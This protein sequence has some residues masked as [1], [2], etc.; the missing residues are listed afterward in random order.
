MAAIKTALVTGSTDGIGLHT[1]TRLANAGWRVLL[2]GRSSESVSAA[3]AAVRRAVPC[4]VLGEYVADLRTL[5]GAHSLATSVLASER[6][7]TCLINNAG[8]FQEA[9]ESAEGLDTTFA[10][11]VA[12]PFIL[13]VR[14]LPLLSLSRP[15]R[16]VN[17]SSISQNDFGRL[18]IGQLPSWSYRPWDPYA[19][20]SH[21]KVAVA[22]LSLELSYRAPVDATGVLVLS[23]DPGTVNTKM[24]IA[25][26]GRC[27][28]EVEEADDEFTLATDLSLDDV[29]SA[30]HGSYCVG[31][32]VARCCK[33]V[34]DPL[35]RAQLWTYLEAA[36]G[37]SFKLPSEPVFVTDKT[38]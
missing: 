22:A 1:A 37:V 17:V 10:V 30:R 25:G 16:I 11:N 15:A 38:G 19:V 24:L 35:V 18:D 4:A 6:Q 33:A 26:W 34:Y 9:P 14:L 28:I 23:C 29:P 21:S 8:V 3:A 27:G 2:H 13:A 36:C 7:L 31:L 5:T 20:Y 12:A 32:R